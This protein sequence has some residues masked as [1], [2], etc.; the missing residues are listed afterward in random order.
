MTGVK[1]KECCDEHRAMYETVEY[2][3]LESNTILY[4]NEL[5]LNK[6]LK[7]TKA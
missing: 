2:C 7:S 3:T 4:V 5:E 6:K 1:V